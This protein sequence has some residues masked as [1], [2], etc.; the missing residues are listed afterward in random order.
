[1]MVV[2]DG[3]FTKKEIKQIMRKVKRKLNSEL[4]QGES[5]RSSEENTELETPKKKRK[6]TVDKEPCNEKDGG[7]SERKIKGGKTKLNS[8]LR[9]ILKSK[10]KR[11][12]TIS[13]SCGTRDKSTPTSSHN[14]LDE[15]ESVSEHSGNDSVTS[16]YSTNTSDSG[17]SLHEDINSRIVALD[18]EFVG[19]GEPQRSALGRVSVL[20]YSGWYTV[21]K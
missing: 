9:R 13:R 17:V 11:I 14:D 6:K 18:C 7:D 10:E 16:D 1:M 15:I 3:E 8:R 2:M 12:S 19:V 5:S 21:E 4:S 20:D